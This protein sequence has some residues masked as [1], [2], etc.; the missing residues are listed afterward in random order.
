MS[1]NP[2]T[3][4][5][6]RNLEKKFYTSLNLRFDLVF[7]CFPSYAHFGAF[8]MKFLLNPITSHKMANLQNTVRRL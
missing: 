3:K 4:Q 7:W 2:V 6:I 1:L 5:K 8:T